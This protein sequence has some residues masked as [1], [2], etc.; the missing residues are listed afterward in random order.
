LPWNSNWGSDYAYPGHD[1]PQYSAPLRFVDLATEDGTLPV[2]ADFTLEEVMQEWKGRY[3][4]FQPHVVARLQTIREL[5]GAA[6][7]INSG[8]RSPAYNSSVGGVTFSRHMFGDAADMWS[9]GASVSEIGDLCNQLGASYVGLYSNFTHCDWR[10][11]PLEPAFYGLMNWQSSELPQHTAKLARH[12]ND[13]SWEAPAT[14]FDE[15]E[16]LRVWTAI[17]SNGQLIARATGATYTPPTGAAVLRVV[18][19]G[20]VELERLLQD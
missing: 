11:E 7:H 18:V 3:G 17:D 9:D 10:N 16:P 6:L 12:L 4:V 8:Y 15:G 19:G 2:A 5:V 1:S 20:H 13:T 14:G